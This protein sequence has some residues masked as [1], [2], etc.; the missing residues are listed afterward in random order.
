VCMPG[1]FLTIWMELWGFIKSSVQNKAIHMEHS[2][3]L[4][5]QLRR[6]LGGYTVG[7]TVGF[8]VTTVEALARRHHHRIS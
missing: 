4:S 7:T 1:H 8:R 2:L 5:F 3:R 6:S